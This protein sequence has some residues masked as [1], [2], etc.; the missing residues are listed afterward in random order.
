M[1]VH[2]LNGDALREQFPPQ[3]EGEIIVAR[4]CLV[5][6]EVRGSNLDEFWENRSAFLEK[7][8]QSS[9]IDYNDSVVSEFEKILNLPLEAQVHLWFEKDLFCQVNL[10]FCA[11]LLHQHNFVAEVYLVLPD[12]D[13][14]YGFGGMDQEALIKA[15]EHHQLLPPDSRSGLAALW[16]AYQAGDTDQMQSLAREL[17][18]ELDFVERAVAAQIDRS[19]S[20]GKWG[21]PEQS[22][23]NIMKELDTDDFAPVFREF[24]KREAIYGFGD[25]QVKRMWEELKQDL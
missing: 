17:P 16:L 21:R 13:L 9:P 3:L 2:I 15:F 10:W 19:P 11:H 7:N 24:S 6:G 20:N 22:L 25:L 12:R 18:S 1:N 5:D 8:Y 14:R 23:L 4:E